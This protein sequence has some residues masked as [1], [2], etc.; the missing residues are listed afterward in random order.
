MVPTLLHMPTSSSQGGVIAQKS[1]QALFFPHMLNES[2][3]TDP[4]CKF[5]DHLLQLF[6]SCLFLAGAVAA[7]IG[8]VTCKRYGRKATMV[9]GEGAFYKECLEGV[10]VAKSDRKGF[11]CERV[12]EGGRG[13][14]PLSL[15]RVCLVVGWVCVVYWGRSH[16][17]W[18]V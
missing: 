1:F 16:G 2:T 9:A 15:V 11:V 6:T 4:F 17:G 12:W 18:V 13:G 14:G 8:S 5:D 7:V 10:V 3:S